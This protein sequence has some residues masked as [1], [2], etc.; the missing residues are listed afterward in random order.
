MDFDIAKLVD[1][2]L[3]KELIEDRNN[4][5]HQSPSFL[6]EP[7][8]IVMRPNMWHQV[9]IDMQNDYVGANYEGIVTETFFRKRK[10]KNVAGQYTIQW[11]QYI[12][13]LKKGG[14]LNLRSNATDYSNYG[15]IRFVDSRYELKRNNEESEW[16]LDAK[17]L[18]EYLKSNC[19]ISSY[20][21]FSYIWNENND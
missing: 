21:D 8:T 2:I 16:F 20:G 3:L 18:V 12:H 11:H 9:G 6:P 5:I 10:E 19:F 17:S 15:S 1:E 7:M 4:P 14:Y 13:V